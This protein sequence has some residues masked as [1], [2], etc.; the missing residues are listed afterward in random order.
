MLSIVAVDIFDNEIKLPS[1][2]SLSVNQEIEVPADDF[3]AVF[4][5]IKNLPELKKVILKENNEVVFMGLVDEQ[6]VISDGD[7]GYIKIVARSMASLLLDN[8]SRPVNY[9][10]PSTNVIFEKHLKPLGFAEFKG[11]DITLYDTLNVYKG[12]TNWQAFYNFVKRVYGRY[13]RI[14]ADGKVDFDGIENSET[15]YFSNIDGMP[16]TSIKENIKRCDV[17]SKVFVKTGENSGYTTEFTNEEAIKKGI[18]RERYLDVTNGISTIDTARKILENTKTKGYEIT[19]ITPL[20]LLNV[21]GAKAVVKD[22]Y[23]G[24]IENLYVNSVYYSLST[25]GEFTTLILKKE[26]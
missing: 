12:M 1:P 23:I 14:E 24:E 18:K 4:M 11:E 3:T 10:N 5:F 22:E 7:S 2:K 6:Q 9:C 19:V 25:Q 13:P 15:M 20:R 16:Y 26:C 21:L 8:E 17:V